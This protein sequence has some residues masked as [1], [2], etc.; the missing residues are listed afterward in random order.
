MNNMSKLLI[1]LIVIFPLTSIAQSSGPR[2]I[3]QVGCHRHDHICYIVISGAAVG[4]EECKSTS[5]R[6]NKNDP[7]GEAIFTLVTSAFY[8]DKQI[9]FTP[10]NSCFVSQSNYPTMSYLSVVK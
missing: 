5:I 3:T 7:N 8:A 1:L 6:W 2:T 9:Q 4:P 10:S